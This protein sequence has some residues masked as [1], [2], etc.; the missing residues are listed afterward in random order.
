[1]QL[2][3][4]PT[5]FA[6]PF[7][8]SA[9]FTNVVPQNPT[10]SGA[11]SLQ[12]GFPAVNF[13]T[14][15][16]LPNHLQDFNGLL[17]QITAW[18]QW[19]NA[20][21][22]IPFDSTFSAVIGGY[23][24]GAILASATTAGNLWLSLVDNNT[25]NPDTVQLLPAPQGD[26]LPIPGIIITAVTYTIDASGTAPGH[27]F[28]LTTCLGWLSQFRIAQSGS[29]TIN[30]IAGT[31]TY[32]QFG[33][34]T[35][36]AIIIDHP[37]ADRITINGASAPNTNVNINYL[38]NPGANGYFLIPNLTGVYDGNPNG[39]NVNI[40]TWLS[41]A[42]NLAYAGY[43]LAQLQ[44]A[45]AT[46]LQFIFP[47]SNNQQ[48]VGL[49]IK[50]PGVTINNILLIGTSPTAGVT[51]ANGALL[52]VRAPATVSN[53]S[54]VSGNGSTFLMPGDG[55]AIRNGG[56][57]QITGFATLFTSHSANRS[58]I[59]IEDGGS[60]IYG[61]FD[62][63]QSLQNIM[64]VGAGIDCLTVN[65]GCV[66]APVGQGGS[67]FNFTGG[68][69]NGVNAQ[70]GGAAD[71]SSPV[72]SFLSFG[73]AVNVRANGK[74]HVKLPIGAGVFSSDTTL[75]SINPMLVTEGSVLEMQ[76]AILGSGSTTNAT[77][78][79][80]AGSFIDATSTSTLN[81]SYSP[82][83]NTVGNSRSYILET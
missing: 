21:G 13:A 18:D 45:Y 80:D 69:T 65:S 12:T 70:N 42:A 72:A 58:S 15:S 59:N 81:W 76:A 3:Q 68:I 40:N 31:F 66:G 50:T 34:V 51:S 53:I 79:A 30:I 60:L 10:G 36:S 63:G 8:S 32:G 6:T 56:A 19:Y 74:S 26:W 55:I 27:F 75:G 20:G 14:T 64:G 49:I 44:L 78:K 71:F 35:P 83:G 41:G 48:D 25:I 62:G 73:F 9:T 24:Q 61:I 38:G 54:V 5:K 23:P 11:A 22:T 47:N 2:S 33:T 1:M 77:I 82:A 28:D 16:G 7:G 52:D 43:Y 17:N 37:N 29:V 46:Q 67:N 4:A 39:P 57:L